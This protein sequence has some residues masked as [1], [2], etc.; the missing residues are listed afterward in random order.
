MAVISNNDIAQAIFHSSVGKN[1]AELDAVSKNIF[2]MLLN[3]R[4]L[5]R[6]GAIISALKKLVN[7]SNNALEV[8]VESG[9]KLTD[10]TKATLSEM[11]SKRYGD[12]KF[13]FTE[14]IDPSLI[15]GFK[16]QVGDESIDFS[17]SN[18]INKLKDYLTK[19]NA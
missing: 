18:K 15:Q 19:S 11:L 4:L 3:R 17:L 10:A 6:S 7:Q 16:V 9:E 12:K 2:R 5:A 8:R 1:G 13:V 14:K